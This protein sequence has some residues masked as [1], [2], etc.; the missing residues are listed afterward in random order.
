M[1][2]FQLKG[3]ILSFRFDVGTS[4]PTGSYSR[5][6]GFSQTLSNMSVGQTYFMYIS[7]T[8]FK[9]DDITQIIDSLDGVQSKQDVPVSVQKVR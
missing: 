1:S 4:T 2:V 8:N 5:N 3:D 7:T 6:I 9:S